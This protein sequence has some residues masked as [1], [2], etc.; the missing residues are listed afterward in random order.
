MPHYSEVVHAQF[1]DIYSD[2]PHSLSS[3]SMKQDPEP[4]TLLVESFYPLAD[5][6]DWL[7]RGKNI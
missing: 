4:L 3:I 7:T 1:T 2:F 5:L 6:L